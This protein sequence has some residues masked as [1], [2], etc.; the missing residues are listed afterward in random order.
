VRW[1][2]EKEAKEANG[3]EAY[4]NAKS[5]EPRVA[6]C[7]RFHNKAGGIYTRHH[8]QSAVVAAEIAEIVLID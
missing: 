6:P 3:N 2:N 4:L 7:L 5:I 1:A 8:S